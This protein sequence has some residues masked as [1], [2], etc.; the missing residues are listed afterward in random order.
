MTDGRVFT[1]HR[2]VAMIQLELIHMLLSA[3]SE[4]YSLTYEVNSS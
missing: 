4:V 1:F 2:L 3:S